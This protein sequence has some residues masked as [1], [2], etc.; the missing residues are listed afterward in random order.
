M[1]ELSANKEIVYS[2][3]RD[4]KIGN[5]EY[6]GMELEISF[7]HEKH[8]TRPDA[9]QIHKNLV[10]KNIAIQLVNAISWGYDSS[11]DN[12]IETR[13]PPMTYNYFMQSREVEQVIRYLETYGATA[14]H[15]KSNNGIHMHVNRASF[16]L[17]Q[18]YKFIRFFQTNQGFIRHVA[19]R[20]VFSNGYCNIRRLSNA[21]IVNMIKQDYS[22]KFD[23]INMH[24]PTVECRIFQSTTNIHAIRAYWQFMYA[25]KRFVEV[26]SV[27]NLN[28]QN[29]KSFVTVKDFRL[30]QKLMSTENKFAPNKVILAGEVPYNA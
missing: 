26:A 11:V 25:L 1:P 29:F 6:F 20:D 2:A 15:N 5:D 16:T 23:A 24:G 10:K 4:Q 14:W 3:N 18:L 12:G 13:W 21:N 8:S 17:I 28:E 22:E 7:S 30:L 27:K 9:E 19:R